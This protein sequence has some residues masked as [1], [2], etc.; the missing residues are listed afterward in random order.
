MSAHDD[1]VTM[2]MKMRAAQKDF[3]ETKKRSSM[4]IAVKLETQVDQFLEKYVS[5]KVQ[6]EMWARSMQ[7]DEM[8]GVYNV[9]NETKTEQGSA[10]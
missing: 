4:V 6:L 9:A 7:T 3:F 1:F 5:E 8:P 2:V 10:T